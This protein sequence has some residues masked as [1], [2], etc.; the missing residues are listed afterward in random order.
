MNNY[1][2][3]EIPLIFLTG[4]EPE[5]E[6]DEEWEFVAKDYLEDVKSYVDV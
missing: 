4:P 6:N 3:L 2:L 1:L 5:E